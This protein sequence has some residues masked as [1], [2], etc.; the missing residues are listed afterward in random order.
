VR[1]LAHLTGASGTDHDLVVHL[2]DVARRARELAAQTRTD[3][4]MLM[5]LAHWAGWLHDLGKYRIEFQEYL[6]GERSRSIETQHAVFGAAAARKL[7]LP[8]AVTFA[9]NG[10]HAGLHDLSDLRE[11]TASPDLAPQ[12]VADHLVQCLRSDYQAGLPTVIRETFAPRRDPQGYAE[13][14]TH[15][16]F[17]VRMLFS[18]LVDADF[19]DTE[20]HMRG[21]E[22][23][24]AA[25]DPAT[26]FALVDREV[27]RLGDRGGDKH[28]IAVRRS[29][30]DEC[31]AKADGLTG[32]FSLTTPTGGG[33][34]LASLAF[35]LRH[36]VR[37]DLRR[38]IVVI[39]FLSII[40]Q[41]ARIYRRVLG[42]DVVVEHHSAV[43]RPDSVAGGSEPRERS[44]AEL[45]AENW[46]APV[47]VT[48]SVQFLE[49]LFARAPS[50][51]R[52]LHNLARSVVILDEVQT[53]P[54][55]L[56]TPTMDVLRELVGHYG[57]SFVFCS[58][59]QPGF[60]RSSGLP[61]GFREGEIR[62]IAPQPARVFATL[63]RVRFELPAVT[64][65][66]WDWETLTQRL[67]GHRQ[68][69]VIVNLRRHAV[70]IY[71][72]LIK[73]VGP[74]ERG[75]VFHL[76]SAMCA[77]HR[78]ATLGTKE[79]PEPGTIY[80]AL[81]HGLPCRAVSTQVVEAGV[82]I[83]FPVVFRAVAPL[84]AVIQSAGRCNREGKLAA[85]D[86]GPGG[87]VVVFRPAD[88]QATPPGLYSFQ[89][90][91]ASD[92]LR[93][94]APDPSQLATDPELYA[95]YY[96]R[97]LDWKPS[98]APRRLAGGQSDKTI[99][100]ERQALN[101]EQV[102]TKA[103]VIEDSGQAIVVPYGDAIAILAKLRGKPRLFRHD[104]RSL[105]R[106]LVNLREPD[107]KALGGLLTP[108]ADE[109][110]PHELESSAYDPKLG[111]K[112]RERPAED[113]VLM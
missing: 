106:F 67:V 65:A 102:A 59:T 56:L 45:A 109:D 57:T 71:N 37:N 112:V 83:D 24:P 51:C 6:R 5:D 38:V 73:T 100:E 96:R 78:F 13:F 89:T 3:R 39:P 110:G 55:H 75:Q 58:A 103:K 87:L 46:D 16:E 53:L 42:D 44:S 111:V 97:F 104:L 32:F 8:L 14:G 43:A 76:S 63:N 36:A 22:R 1:A 69:L 66:P 9:I 23:S 88:P 21:Q 18:C 27:N 12:Q 79:Q 54:H 29:I 19:L 33:K 94:V 15:E 101:F 80:H 68:V 60:A 72:E 34:T 35:A 90:N 52:K 113:F 7:G 95:G 48:T 82:D 64:E 70:E 105:Q 17:L 107:I 99:Q 30:Y 40:E 4:A 91:Q 2:R 62:E 28:L 47:V 31:V 77:E 74:K 108:I 10:H 26:L 11:K 98:D 86:G 49:S 61:S 92:V 20:R 50:R 41:N 93:G 84:D 85:S 25:F 81:A